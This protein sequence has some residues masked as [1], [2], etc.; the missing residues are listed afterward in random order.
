MS[1]TILTTIDANGIAAVTLNRPDV[2]NALDDAMITALT[3]ALRDFEV[4][5]AVRVVLLAANG[6][7]FCA[8]ADINEMRDAAH[9]TRAR[10][11]KS[12]R[13]MAGMFHALHTL[14]KPTVACV[15]GAVRGGGVGL[16]AACDIAI[17]AQSATFRLSE[18]RLGIIPAAISPYMIA[19]VGSRNARRYFLTGETFDA[20]EACRIGL[21]HD[22]VA[23]DDLPETAGNLLTHLLANGP[24][25]VAAA[26]TLIAEVQ[27]QPISDALIKLTAKRIAAIR[28]TAE[29]QEGLAAFLEKREPIWTQPTAAMKAARK[30]ARR[31]RKKSGS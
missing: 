3:A 13:A 11:E 24:N 4:D 29:A 1:D 26:K 8:G 30:P 17:A 22:C 23:D 18:V 28:A 9:H 15:H 27:G 5:P 14:A 2:H 25:A 12:A 6:K 19:A 20:A 16:V 31:S 21:V 10:N 7:H